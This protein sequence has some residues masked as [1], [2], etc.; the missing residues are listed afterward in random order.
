[1]LPWCCPV[2]D[3]WLRVGGWGSILPALEFLE[4]AS[5]GFLTSVWSWSFAHLQCCHCFPLVPVALSSPLSTSCGLQPFFSFALGQ[6][7][8]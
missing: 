5:R 3:A 1:M 6:K 8:W 4:L 7:H 2:G